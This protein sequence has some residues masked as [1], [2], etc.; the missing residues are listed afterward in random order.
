[1]ELYRRHGTELDFRGVVVAP[2]PVSLSDMRRTAV[3]A[4]NALQRVL[5][6]EGVIM[7]K[8]TGG[9]TDVVL[10]ESCEA[11]EKAGIRT[12]L[13]DN[14][15]LKPDG[16]GDAPLIAYTPMA[17]AMVSVGNIEAMV[18]LPAVDVVLGGNQVSGVG[19][20]VHGPIVAPIFAVANGLSQA[21]L[22][23]L[24]TERR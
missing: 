17:D 12:L 5:G 23:Y 2:E 11:C 10:M 13:I 20:D 22:T 21:G 14:E 16:T 19:D 4:T 1:M 9:H 3:M 8:E 18:N 6:A 15:W 7:T 24:T